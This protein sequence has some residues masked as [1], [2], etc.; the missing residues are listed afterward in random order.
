MPT[1]HN[2]LGKGLDALIPNVIPNTQL[3][4]EQIPID[5]IS[6]NRF[7]PRQ[8]FD[9]QTLNELALSI[10]QHGLTQP[11]L[12]RETEGGYELIVGERRLEACKINRSATIPAII[13]NI[14]NK[15]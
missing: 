14:A 12:V 3:T 8:I 10:Q 15:I 4:I 5:E 9:Q 7:Q 2:R 1:Q 6:P 13:K 11:V